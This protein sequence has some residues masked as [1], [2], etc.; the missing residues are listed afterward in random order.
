M[1]KRFA[2]TSI[3]LGAPAFAQTPA[4]TPRQPGAVY[5]FDF[6]GQK[7]APAPRRDISGV[8]EPA[9][10]PGDAIQ[11]NGAKAMPSDGKPEHDLHFTPAG[12]RA[13]REHKPGF[14]TTSVVTA[15][16]NDPMDICDPQGYPRVVLHNFRTSQIVQ[17][18]NQVLIL[19][20]FNR[21]WRVLWNDGRA[22][23]A[24]PEPRWWGY[25]VGK[26]MD[27]YTFV[28]Q[29]TGF[30]DRTWLD[31][32]GRPHSDAL[33]TEERY[34]RVDRDHLEMTVT[35]DD[36]K[37]YTKPWVALDKMSLRLQPPG[38]DIIEMECSPSETRE[39]NKKH[40]DPASRGTN[41]K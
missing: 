17:T 28:A 37:M 41:G 25:S 5:D 33:R 10:G 13:F 27:D 22:L 36:P 38:F 39:Y 15:S 35:I 14:G 2:A 19:Y 23:P 29:S 18:A 30:D 32:A 16:I 21:K 11:A 31:N 40:G 34:H 1:L 24:D 9:R 8:W 12:E 4:Q 3:L 7:P 6:K 20:E 26:W